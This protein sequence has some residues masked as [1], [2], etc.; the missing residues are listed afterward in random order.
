MR[1]EPLLNADVECGCLQLIP[2]V[3]EQEYDPMAAAL[4][5]FMGWEDRFLWQLI[6]HHGPTQTQ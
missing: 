2:E 1:G 6:V 3:S 4:W 5:W